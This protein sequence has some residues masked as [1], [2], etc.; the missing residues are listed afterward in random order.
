MSSTA[1]T[2]CAA[3]QVSVNLKHKFLD[4]RL[5]VFYCSFTG[6]THIE[7][8]CPIFSQKDLSISSVNMSAWESVTVHSDNTVLC[9]HASKGNRLDVQ[10]WTCNQA[11]LSEQYNLLH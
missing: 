7:K 8:Y 10:V 11:M 4:V 9:S 3:V 2:F 1:V 6:L 5:L